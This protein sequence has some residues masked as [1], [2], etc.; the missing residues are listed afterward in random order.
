MS[1]KRLRRVHF[2]PDPFTGTRHL[3]GVL[4]DDP[5]GARFVRSSIS[6]RLSN[7]VQR[8]TLES[9]FSGAEALSD[10]GSLP[11]TI[12]QLVEIGEPATIP[13]GVENIESWLSKVMWPKSRTTRRG[14]QPRTL[15][16]RFFEDAGVSH[17]VLDFDESLFADWLELGDMETLATSE[18]PTQM[19]P[20]E[21]LLLLEPLDGHRPTFIDEVKRVATVAGAYD[22]IVRRAKKR[23]HLQAYMLRKSGSKQLMETR[24]HLE[25]FD[26][27]VFDVDQPDD[28]KRFIEGIHASA[29]SH[30]DA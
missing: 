10:F 18:V 2:T 1:A 8:R 16:R 26:V 6:V 19:V 17:R 20:S 30:F 24:R 5:T 4:I 25:K 28:R 9:I 12:S 13:N 7:A 3:I 14:S 11:G 22:F 15:G 27:E 23:H 29:A 21:H